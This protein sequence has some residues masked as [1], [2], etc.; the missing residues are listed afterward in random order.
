MNIASSLIV[1][2]LY[3]RGP[4]AGTTD[5][6]LLSVGVIFIASLM[7][8]GGGY[9]IFNGIMTAVTTATLGI[10]RLGVSAAS[11]GIAR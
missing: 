10:A 2:M 5:L 4:G 6:M 9:A 8:A 11:G 3:D 1:S 7:T